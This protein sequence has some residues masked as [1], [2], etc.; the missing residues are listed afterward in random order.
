MK[1]NLHTHSFYCGHGRGEIEEYCDYAE[2]HGFDI[3]GFSEHCPFPNDFDHKRRMAYKAHE[4]YENDV[5]NARGKHNMKILLG[6]ECDY[7]P[8]W[9]NY[10]EE[11]K[12]RVDYLIAGTH[13]VI[14][15]D[16]RVATPFSHDFNTK[17]LSF[18]VSSFIE[19]METGLFLFL[20]H[21]DVFLLYYSWNDSAKAAS[22]DILEAAKALNVPLEVNANG[23]IKAESDNKTEW[24]YPNKHF[25]TLAKQ[26]N[27]K[28]VCSSDA[29]AIVNLDKH[30]DDVWSFASSIG[31]DMLEPQIDNGNLTL[32][33]LLEM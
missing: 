15:L 22:V 3:L 14:E 12:G 29:H 4:S 21:P 17:D 8:S 11:L 31:I 24:G 16:G 1:Y 10:F 26:Y 28:A 32:K 9:K 25:W 13:F 5:L 33:S 19:A 2:K 27:I 6:Y 30:Y 23:I 18:Y 20:A 7:F